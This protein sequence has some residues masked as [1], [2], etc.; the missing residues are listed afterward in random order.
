VLTSG[1]DHTLAIVAIAGALALRNFRETSRTLTSAQMAGGWFQ[2]VPTAP[3]DSTISNHENS[4]PIHPAVVHLSAR[5]DP[6][7]TEIAIGGVDA[8]T[9]LLL[10]LSDRV[11]R[12]QDTFRIQLTVSSLQFSQDGRWISWPRCFEFLR[13]APLHARIG[14]QEFRLKV[15]AFGVRPRC[16]T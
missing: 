5:F 13:V 11:T 2:L 7:G 8:A 14:I 10:R 3:P 6:S 16:Y 12:C 4:I 1:R 9:N 15:R